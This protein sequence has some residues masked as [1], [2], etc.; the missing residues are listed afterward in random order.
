LSKKEHLVNKRKDGGM[1]KPKL[2]GSKIIYR[3]IYFVDKYTVVN[4][5]VQSYF[6]INLIYIIFFLLIILWITH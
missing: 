3:I 6:Y 4:N 1:L 2:L 5:I